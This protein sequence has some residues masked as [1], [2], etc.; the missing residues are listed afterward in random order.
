[1]ASLPVGAGSP[2]AQ[3]HMNHSPLF[4]LLAVSTV[5]FACSIFVGGPQLPTPEAAPARDGV[6]TMQAQVEQASEDS[7][8][9]GT[10]RLRLTQEQLTAYISSRLAAQNP[11]LLTDVLVVLSDQHMILYGRGSSGMI[12]ANVVVTAEFGIDSAGLPQIRITDAQL[13]P[14]PMPQALQDVISAAFDEALTG[15]I[16]PAA[17]GFRLESIDISGGVM[18]ITGRVR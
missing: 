5:S 16:G 10:V 13:G 9:T 14:L 6:Q 7:L 3:D 17:I 4:A 18:T 11:P 15:S 1:M 2:R 12:E 8:S